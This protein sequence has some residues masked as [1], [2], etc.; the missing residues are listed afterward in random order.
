VVAKVEWNRGELLPRWGF[1]VTNLSYPPF[2]TM[3][4][5]KTITGELMHPVR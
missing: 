5:V 2:R 3:L 1:I 4:F